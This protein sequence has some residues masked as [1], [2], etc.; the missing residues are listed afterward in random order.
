MTSQSDIERVETLC[1]MQYARADGRKQLWKMLSYGNFVG[2]DEFIARAWL[3][4]KE[5]EERQHWLHNTPEGSAVR[6]A[7]AADQSLAVAAR[8]AQ[9]AERSAK[10]TLWAAIAAAIGAGATAWQAFTV[11]PAGSSMQG[12]AAGAVSAPARP[13]SGR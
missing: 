9:A 8:A 5:A 7:N 4:R 6:Q 3:E 1:A 2:D 11:S 13:A 12:S 10:Y